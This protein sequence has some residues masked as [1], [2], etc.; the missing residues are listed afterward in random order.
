MART[1]SQQ[2]WPT[3]RHA[4]ELQ[5][6]RRR[7]HPL[8]PRLAERNPSLARDSSLNCLMPCSC[9]S[10]CQCPSLAC[11]PGATHNCW[12][13]RPQRRLR[14]PLSLSHLS[15]LPRHGY[16]HLLRGRCGGGGSQA[17]LA[18]GTWLAAAKTQIYNSLGDEPND[19]AAKMVLRGR[20]TP[21]RMAAKSSIHEVRCDC[22]WVL[23]DAYLCRATRR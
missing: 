8:A 14:A 19:G 6:E 11:R 17:Q 15:S 13:H 7:Q 2:P 16:P 1:S 10:L 12:P 21:V 18:E 20:V 5:G 4:P 3:L 9:A 22:G 23:G